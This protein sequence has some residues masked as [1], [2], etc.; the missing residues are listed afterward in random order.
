MGEFIDKGNG[1]YKKGKYLYSKETCQNCN[2]I[3]FKRKDK[4][5]QKCCSISC[6]TE[7]KHKLREVTL[8][9]N[10]LEIINGS[11]LSDGSI[12]KGKK[13]KNYRFSHSSTNEEYI[14]YIKQEL[15]F[16]ITK[17]KL[18]K[19]KNN[20]IP[21]QLTTTHQKVFDDLRK[22]WYKNDKQVPKDLKLT[23]TTILHWF[24]GDGSLCNKTGV[25]LCTDSFNND[26]IDY[27]MKELDKTIKCK[28]YKKKNNRIVIPNKYVYEFFEYIGQSPIYSFLYKW[29]TI[30]K[31]SYLNRKCLECNKLFNAEQ[32]NKLFCS[33]K[34]YKKNW[35][36]NKN[37]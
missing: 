26:S 13:V 10:D 24:L 20:K 28:T 14:D 15:S 23:K 35:Y 33:E 3:F 22:K 4:I 1:F 27:L 17:S 2:E 37:N 21:Y 11:L 7:Y 19:R 18:K 12:T 8:T 31:E 32:N 29:D 25:I 5:K 36:K 9:Q 16:N 30:V 34:C 6:N